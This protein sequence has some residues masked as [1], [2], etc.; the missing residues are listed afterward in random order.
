MKSEFKRGDPK[1]TGKVNCCHKTA[2]KFCLGLHDRDE[3]AHNMFAN[4]LSVLR[5]CKILCHD[6][7]LGKWP[8]L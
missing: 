3:L 6:P 2:P 7:A 8:N 4:Q 5:Q 1:K